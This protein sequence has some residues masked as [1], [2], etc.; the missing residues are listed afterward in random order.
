MRNR[1]YPLDTNLSSQNV[2]GAAI[3]LHFAWQRN[4]I[5]WAFFVVLSLFILSRITSYALDNN[6]HPSDG[7]VFVACA[8]AGSTV[9]AKKVMDADQLF[10]YVLV[11]LYILSTLGSLL[12][13]VQQRSTIRSKRDLDLMRHFALE[14]SGFPIRSGDAKL[15]DEYKLFFGKAFPDASIVGV[16]IA[17]DTQKNADS[18]G[19]IERQVDA[20]LN[21][22]DRERDLRLGRKL[23]KKITRLD[24]ETA[25]RDEDKKNWCHSID[26][27]FLGALC[28]GS[29]SGESMDESKIVS[30]LCSLTTTGHVFCVFETRADRDKARAQ[31]SLK[32]PDPTTEGGSEIVLRSTEHDPENHFWENIKQQSRREYVWEKGLKCVLCGLGLFIGVTL[33]AVLVYAPISGYLLSFERSPGVQ[34]AHWWD[35]LTQGLL[36]SV[37]IMISNQVL[38]AVCETLAA[39][40]R[41]TSK[42]M[43]DTAYVVM[44][45]LFITYQTV[46]DVAIVIQTA[47]GQHSSNTWQLAQASGVLGPK[48]LAQNPTI[49]DTMYV[50]MVAYLYPGTLL[51]PYLAEP[52]CM[53]MGQYFIFKWLI[54]SNPS[55]GIQAAENLL[56]PVPY[57]LTRY[58]DVVISVTCCVLVLFIAT[59]EVYQIFLYLIFML[60]FCYAWDHWRLLRM[61]PRCFEEDSKLDDFSI[62]MLSLPCALLAAAVTFRK[63]GGHEDPHMTRDSVPIWCIVVFFMHLAVHLAAFIFIL[64]RDKKTNDAKEA[65]HASTRERAGTSISL[66]DMSQHVKYGQAAEDTAYNWFNTNLVHCL[67]SKYIYKNAPVWCVPAKCGREYLL[68][69]HTELGLFYEA[70]DSVAPLSFRSDFKTI[71]QDVRHHATDALQSL[72]MVKGKASPAAPSASSAGVG[73]H[74]FGTGGGSSASKGDDT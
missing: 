23:S 7:D 24:L 47:Y 42:G 45:T 15:E 69:R 1:T 60:V 65:S 8:A 39:K 35:E 63:Y 25:Q 59:P 57:D 19:D 26:N 34:R 71:A 12:M 32:Y 50:K 5:I 30:D 72:H 74:L 37:P 18:Q 58:G 10:F 46:L 67:R 52:L 38:Y 61:T 20:E 48:A 2:S 73:I 29:E 68:M 4:V 36:L 27:V 66:A 54:R 40:I 51:L 31:V 14:A 21:S 22:L 55:I 44:Y 53:G 28:G 16:S 64:A 62:M 13:L 11:G 9:L 43:R 49:R 41:F 3:Q 33:W 70:P 56:L 17:W 6:T